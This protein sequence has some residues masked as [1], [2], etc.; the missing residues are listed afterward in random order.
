MD[1]VDARCNHE[2]LDIVDA[3]CNHEVL[4]TVYARCNHDV[5]LV[6]SLHFVAYSIIIMRILPLIGGF[7]TSRRSNVKD[8]IQMNYQ[9]FLLRQWPSCWNLDFYL[10]VLKLVY[11]AFELHAL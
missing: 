2:V 5:Y 4:D 8:K 3:R 10:L 6:L 1:I 7:T 9:S 11:N